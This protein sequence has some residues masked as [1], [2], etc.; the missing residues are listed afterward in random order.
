MSI[1][2][3]TLVASGLAAAFAVVA[4]PR[5]IPQ[6]RQTVTLTGCLRTGSTTSIYLLRGAA[7]SSAGAAQSPDGAVTE[8]RLED[9]LLVVP[10]NIDL[11]PHVNHR[12]A[13]T[14][15]RTDAKD[16]PPPPQGANTAEKALNR[17]SVQSVKEV[18]SNCS[19][20]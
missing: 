15:V 1:I 13:V 5:L 18:A 14:G 20:G 19:G 3:S 4:V 10:S 2:K 6:E 9:L 12:I 7:G 8:A 16:A 11:A 17:L